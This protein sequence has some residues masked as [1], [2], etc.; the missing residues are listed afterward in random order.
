[1]KKTM[2]LALVALLLGASAAPSI[3]VAQD[4]GTD[5]RTT[6]DDDDDDGFDPGLLGLLGLLGL[7]GLRRPK[8]VVHTD[9][10]RDPRT[11]APR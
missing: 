2:N 5:T 4:A 11:G 9:P 6:I 7:A 1:M 10:N 3:A 8:T